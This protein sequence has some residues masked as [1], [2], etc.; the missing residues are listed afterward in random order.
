[1]RERSLVEY[2]GE[3]G[4]WGEGKGKSQVRENRRAGLP[5]SRK[6]NCARSTLAATNPIQEPTHLTSPH[7]TQDRPTLSL[8]YTATYLY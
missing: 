4:M 3:G 5:G 7:P 2:D 1:M 6:P 8:E